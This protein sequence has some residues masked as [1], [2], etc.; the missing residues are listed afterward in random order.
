MG[1]YNIVPELKSNNSSVGKSD[2]VIVLGRQVYN[3]Q[4]HIAWSVY[5]QW[6][7]ALKMPQWHLGKKLVW[8]RLDMHG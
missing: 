3:G 2:Y 1:L 7:R 4:S 6:G 5:I 8:H